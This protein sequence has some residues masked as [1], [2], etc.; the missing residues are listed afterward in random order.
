[1]IKYYPDLEQFADKNDDAVI[2]FLAFK[3]VPADD[4]EDIRQEF[5]LRIQQK[6]LLPYLYMVLPD[7]ATNY[8][9]AILD[10]IRV[11]YFRRQTHSWGRGAAIP[12]WPDRNDLAIGFEAGRPVLMDGTSFIDSAVIISDFQRFVD[13]YSVR[14]TRPGE[15]SSQVKAYIEQVMC[16]ADIDS[17]CYNVFDRYRSKYLSFCS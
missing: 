10:N 12:T 9:L 1:M 5:Y 4:R 13:R 3:M 14:S 17:N 16:G 8:L 15:A 7:R 6:N 11:E 2:S